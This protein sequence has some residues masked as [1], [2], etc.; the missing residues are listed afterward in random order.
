MRDA[1]PWVLTS[2]SIMSETESSADWNR[3]QTTSRILSEM[4]TRRDKD[5]TL[6][7]HELAL[8]FLMM[9]QSQIAFRDRR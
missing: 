6:L 4:E 2:I 5:S 9:R 8:L 1:L 7:L 3:S